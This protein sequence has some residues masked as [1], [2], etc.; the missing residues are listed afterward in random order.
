MRGWGGFYEGVKIRNRADGR[1]HTGHAKGL[2]SLYAHAL[3]GNLGLSFPK[4]KVEAGDNA[5]RKTRAIG[6]KAGFTMSAWLN[7]LGTLDLAL[8][9]LPVG[10][11]YFYLGNTIPLG[12]LDVL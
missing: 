9:Q 8:G 12:F 10:D 6:W 11:W 2:F 5:N 1:N 7:G 3:A 4:G